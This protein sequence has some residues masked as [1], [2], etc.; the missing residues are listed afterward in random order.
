MATELDIV[1]WRKYMKEDYTIGHLSMDSEFICDTIEDKV[2]DYNRDG[3]LNDLGEAK[4]YDETAIPFGRYRVTLEMSPKFKRKLPYLHNVKGFEGVL[5]HSGNT[6][7]DSAGCIIVG[8]NKAP[9]LVID[10]RKFELLIVSRIEAAVK[11]GKKVYITI[12]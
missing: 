8:R 3:D 10:S 9:G 12:K 7:I 1:L 5:I 6:A 11:Q 4:V 2:R